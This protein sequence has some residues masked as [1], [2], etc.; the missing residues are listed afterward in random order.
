MNRSRLPATRLG[1]THKF[2]VGGTKGYITVGLFEDGRVGEL[3]IKLDKSELNGWTN[4]VGILTS[5]LLQTGV[6]LDI[7]VSKMEY[8]RFAPWGPTKHPK[9]RIAHS[10]L[11]Y[12]FRWL[13]HE[14]IP[15]YGKE[16]SNEVQNNGTEEQP[17]RVRKD[18]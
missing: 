11:D 3:F 16:K 14:F 10:I 7:I 5:I 6:P 1:V 4:A 8:Q 13:G 9:I 12:V 17:A 15:D 18:H 2:N